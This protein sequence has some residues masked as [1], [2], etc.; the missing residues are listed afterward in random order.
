MKGCFFFTGVL[1]IFF[2]WGIWGDVRE[3]DGG[4]LRFEGIV[5]RDANTRN[6]TPKNG[7]GQTSIAPIPGKGL[8]P[9]SVLT[10]TAAKI[11]P[12]TLKTRLFSFDSRQKR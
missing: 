9:C 11:A 7:R 12:P 6:K 8:T 5:V 3:G 1:E 4:D 2:W 10:Y